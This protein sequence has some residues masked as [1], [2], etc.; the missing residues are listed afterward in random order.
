MGVYSSAREMRLDPLDCALQHVTET[1]NLLETLLI[2]SETF[3]YPAA[4][5]ALVKLHKKARQLGKLQA[6]LE[7]ERPAGETNIRILP[8]RRTTLKALPKRR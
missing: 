3:D 1:K 8:F 6:K 5:E 7:S 2:S 4:K